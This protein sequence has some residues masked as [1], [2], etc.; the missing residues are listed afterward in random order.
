MHFTYSLLLLFTLSYPLIK[1]FEDKIQF[2][3]KWRFLFP[4][5]IIS[6]VVFISWDIWFTSIGIWKFNTDFVLGPFIYNLPFEEW[7]FFLIT[8]FSCIFIYEV[9]NY[10]IKKDILAKQ[11]KIIT[12]T[13][14][15]SLFILAILYHDKLYTFVDFI[16]LSIF[17]FLHQYV[18]RSTYL[19]RFYITWAVCII[20]FLIVNGVITGMPIVIYNDLENTT[21]RIFTIPVE[22][23]FYGMLQFLLV[24]TIYEYLKSKRK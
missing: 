3:K 1:S 6:A 23:M 5:I 16:S 17:L 13:I 12:N 7:L 19:A 9:L 10:F 4:A 11:S 15:I 14:A 22:D 20:P 21:F 24:M 8:P 2:Y 18:F